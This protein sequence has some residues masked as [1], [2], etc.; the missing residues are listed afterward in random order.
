MGNYY[1]FHCSEQGYNHIKV[2]KV[3]QDCSGST[4]HGKA[5]IAVVADGHG[6]DN[7]PRTDRGSRF[8]VSAA[9]NAVQ[10]FIDA[11]YDNQ[12]DISGSWES[13]LEQLAKSILAKWHNQVEDDVSYEPFCDEE[14]EKV[15]EKYKTR[16]Q[17]PRYHA[18]AYGTTL[19]LA[20][21]TPDF[22]FGMQIGDGK[23]VVVTQNGEIIEPIPWDDDCQQNVTTSI[24]DNDAINEFR[25]YFSKELPAAVFMG[26]DGVDDSYASS[27]E[28]HELYRSV[29]VI[30][31]ENGAE[32]GEKEISEYLPVISRKGSGDD[33]SV[34]GLVDEKCN[35]EKV[36]LI[37]AQGDY[38]RAVKKKEEAE[39]GCLSS[40]ER[41][42]YMEAA[43]A[44][45]QR[46]YDEVLEKMKRIQKE[47]EASQNAVQEAEAEL[48]EAM[49]RIQLLQN[50]DAQEAPQTA[51]EECAEEIPAEDA[52]ETADAEVTEEAEKVDQ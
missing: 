13:Y 15:S 1:A 8:A 3:N 9:M 48:Q 44:Q 30:F 21:I 42:S 27:E 51:S 19:I 28:L 32:V 6:S 10:E 49:D 16:Y 46:E 38:Y 41:L 5:A 31:A 39:N 34:A 14:L 50:A 2:G 26:S 25:F 47:L 23:C 40:K 20:C 52:V 33:I 37:K 18:K 43:V 29:L 24:C 45:K 12:I 22:W 17:S 7:Y 36:A 35:G 4:V 11:V